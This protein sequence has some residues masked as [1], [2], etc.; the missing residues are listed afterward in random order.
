MI[1]YNVE[2]YVEQSIKS[3]LDQTYKDIELII[4]AGHGTDAS[5]E[6]CRRYAKLDPRIKL[7]TG[8][9]KGI[10][11]ARNQG[12]AEVTGDWL[13]FVDS[14]DYIEPDMFRRMLD[15][16]TKYDADI[17]VCGRF[18]EYVGKTLSDS[19]AEP[20]VLDATQALSVTLGHEGF[21]LHCWDKLFSRK[22]FEGLYFRTDITVED[23]IVVD[24]LLSSADRIVYDPT[25][26]YHFRERKGSCSKKS[27]MVRKNVEANLLMEE[28][29]TKE[30]PELAN[31]CNRFMLYE[32]IT[33]LQNELVSDE[34]DKE[35]IKEYTK[36]IA[37]LAG[38][39]NPLIGRQLRIKTFMAL[40]MPG[41]LKMYTKRARV[42]G[43]PASQYRPR[44]QGFDYS[45]R[46]GGVGIHAPTAGRRSIPCYTV[47]AGKPNHGLSG[48]YDC[49]ADD[50]QRHL[51]RGSKRP[52]T[53]DRR[54]PKH[55]HGLRHE[56]TG[57]LEPSDKRDV[58]Y[59][60]RRRDEIVRAV[61]KH[62]GE[63]R[64]RSRI[65]HGNGV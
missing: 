18:Y 32:F 58:V 50:F 48:W 65:H 36:K 12:L 41:L 17:S 20:V 7:I 10:A 30:H 11:D 40:Y 24:R 8:E 13:G 16:M 29:L 60:R 44:S 63:N 55:G 21:F 6:I 61:R 33:A 34:P 31:E 22:V 2:P 35:D 25:P 59:Q 43:A 51:H 15:N 46:S 47:P 19:P 4:V 9:A 37:V 54:C 27:G 57:P 45:P 5:E 23:R 39:K 42:G 56:P 62:R 26:M 53:R 64:R 1:V 28:F 3:V 38:A 14:D 49:R 52:S